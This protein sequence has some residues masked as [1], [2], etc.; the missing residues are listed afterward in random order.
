[1]SII[2]LK[3]TKVF[4]ESPE[5][6]ENRLFRGNV[7]KEGNISF[8]MYNHAE[9][10]KK[11]VMVSQGVCGELYIA[12]GSDVVATLLAIK[13]KTIL[14]TYVDHSNPLKKMFTLGVRYQIEDGRALGSVA[15]YVFDKEGDRWTLYREE[16]GFSAGGIALFE[17]KYS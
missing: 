11:R 6:R 8:M 1:M 5:L 9:N 13:T 3:V 10:K 14:C 16:V 15:G 4:G 17:A 2:K 7:D 12:N